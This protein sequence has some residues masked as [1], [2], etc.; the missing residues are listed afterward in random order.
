MKEFSSLLIS[1]II[2]GLADS[3]DAFF[4]N[5][6][7]ID[8]IIVCGSMFTM[9]L[10]FRS[11]GEM[12]IYTY[13]TVRKNEWQY[14]NVNIILSL[15]VGIFVFFSR[16]YIVNLFSITET[17]KGLLVSILSIYVLYLII[18][19]VSN[20]LFE[21]TRLKGDLKTY[22]KSLVLFYVSLIFLDFIF[23]ITTKNLILLFIATIISWVIVIIYM[24]AK[25]KLKFELPTVETLKNVKKYGIPTTL[26]RL[27]SRLFILVYGVIAS[28]LGIDKYSIHTICYSVCLSLE[29]ITNAYNAALMIKIPEEKDK[30]KQFLNAKNYRKKFFWAIILLN[31][32][33]SFVYLFV[34]HGSLPLNKCFPY[35]IIY[36]TSV[37]GLINYETYKAICVVQGKQKILLLGSTIGALIRVIICLLFINTSINL[38]IFGIVNAIDFYIRSIVYKSKLEENKK[39]IKQ[40][41]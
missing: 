8:T 6:I 32:I 15:I 28:H 35:I 21:I 7:S 38:Y 33:F 2:M 31:F 26:E 3:V 4:N 5:A 12:G 36:S 37:F 11:I 14:L 22:N 17:Q 27:L 9:Q 16:N 19:R 25:L 24:L 34:S 18:G 13:R 29:I 39:I 1:F 40:N 20:A 10:L 41:V 30:S 23:F